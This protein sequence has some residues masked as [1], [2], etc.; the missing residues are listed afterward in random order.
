MSDEDEPTVVLGEKTEVEGVPL[1]RIS[2]RLMWGIEKESVIEREGETTIRTPDGP[3][4]LSELLAEVSEPYFATQREFEHAVR[5][6]M[7]TGPVPTPGE[8]ATD[9]SGDAE[10]TEDAEPETENEEGESAD[11]SGEAESEE[12]ESEESPK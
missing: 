6:V 2:A 8:N 7:G 5:E 9:E 4:A 3:R 10:P 1:A 11:E 12:P